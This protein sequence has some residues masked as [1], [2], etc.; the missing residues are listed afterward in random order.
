M[1]QTTKRNLPPPQESFVD[2]GTL[3]LSYTGYQY[4]LSLLSF[5]S[6]APATATV[7]TNLVATGANQA[8]ALQLSTQ[9]S[10]VN[11]VA[12]GTGVLLQLLQP[13]QNQTVYNGGAN[14]LSVYPSPGF[15]IDAIAA[16]A[17]YSLGAGLK[18]TFDT[19]SGSQIRS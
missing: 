5:A 13:G 8:T 18:R 7:V 6:K 11:T 12:S 10:Q 16:N 14:A 9:W 19:W 4:L 15:N 17:P 3:N 2:N 1:V